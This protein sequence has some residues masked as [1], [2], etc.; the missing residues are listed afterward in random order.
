[1]GLRG[2][3]GMGYWDVGCIVS[4]V[5]GPDESNEAK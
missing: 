4:A 1:M 3:G 5:P 2:V